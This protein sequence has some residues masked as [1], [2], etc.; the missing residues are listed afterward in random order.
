MT[1]PEQQLTVRFRDDGKYIAFHRAKAEEHRIPP[2]KG[3]RW[4]PPSLSPKHKSLF[5]I[6]Q[7]GKPDR[8]YQPHSIYRLGLAV[9]GTPANSATTERLMLAAEIRHSARTLR[10]ATIQRIYAVSEDESRLFVLVGYIDEV[11]STK[12]HR[13]FVDVPFFLDL[14]TKTLTDVVP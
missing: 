10:S 3:C 12:N 4:T 5:V 2:P 7:R 14:K 1:I 6:A 11:R 8:G 9:P 13:Y